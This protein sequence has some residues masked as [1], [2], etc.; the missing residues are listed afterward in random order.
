MII[1][2]KIQHYFSGLILD[3]NVYS[4]LLWTKINQR[5][6]RKKNISWVFL[7]R[8]IVS[9]NTVSTCFSQKQMT[10]GIF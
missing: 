9:L 2:L 1:V 7:N 5:I 10:K 3:S 4:N 8:K 6:K